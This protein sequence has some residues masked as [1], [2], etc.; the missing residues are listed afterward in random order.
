[1][2]DGTQDITFAIYDAEVAGNEIWAE[3]IS[4]TFD[5]GFFSVRLG[6]QLVLDEIVFDGSTRWLGITVGSDPEMTPRAAIVSVPYAMFAG[7]VRGE[8]NPTSVNIQGFGQVINESGQWVGD[9]SG[10]IGP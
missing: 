4:V 6:E 1:P 3:T 5:E 7:D 10:L 9:P 8:I 2:V